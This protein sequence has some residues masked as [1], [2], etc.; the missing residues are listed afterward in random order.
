MIALSKFLNLPRQADIRRSILAGMQDSAG[1]LFG[2]LLFG[3]LFGS[4]AK[5]AGLDLPQTVAMSAFIF[6]GTAQFA[7]LALWSPDMP[8]FAIAVSTAMVT[9]RLTLMGLTLAPMVRALPGVAKGPAVFLI[10]DAAWVLTLQARSVPSKGAYYFGVSAPL[11]ILWVLATVFGVMIAGVFDPVTTK[12]LAFAGIVF[13]S[14]LVG[15]V[16]RG[17]DAPRP[18][19]VVAAVVA[20]G[21]DGVVSAGASVLVSVAAGAITAIAAEMARHDR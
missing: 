19:L 11:Y 3:V 2:S 18:P 5:V 8:L 21:L 7:T 17:V 12:A 6:A 15:M 13:L 1:M 10:N 20:I 4:A 16:V 14:I 9:S